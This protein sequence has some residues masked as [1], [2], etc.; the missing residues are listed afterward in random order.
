M[1][2]SGLRWV[3]YQS[4]AKK[5]GCSVEE[6]EHLVKSHLVRGLDDGDLRFVAENDIDDLDHLRKPPPVDTARIARN[7]SLIDQRLKRIEEAVN[8]LFEANGLT[9][10]K[11]NHLEDQTLTQLALNIDQMLDQVE[12]PIQRLLSCAEVFLKLSEVEVERLG[13]LTGREDSWRPFLELCLRQLT[14]LS[15]KPE[16]LEQFEWARARDLLYLALGNLRNVSMNYCNLKS[17]F[18][19]L[20]NLASNVCRD[21]VDTI[22]ALIIARRSRVPEI[23]NT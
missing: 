15:R 10:F 16:L 18:R 20:L 4:A 17:D 5:L 3:S 21:D 11:M 7:V 1:G 8:L 22:E 23:S 2:R 9:S 6:V 13:D 19:P 12:W 14:W